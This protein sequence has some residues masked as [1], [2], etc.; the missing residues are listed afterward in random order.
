[1]AEVIRLTDS[2]DEPSERTP[3]GW[4]Q[5]WSKEKTAADKRLRTFTNQGN[6]VV[7]RFLDDRGSAT[8]LRGQGSIPCR[9]NL[10]WRNVSTLQAMLYGN[11]PKID[12]SREHH[13]PDDDIARVAATLYERMLQTDI[14]ASGEDLPT[15]LKCALQDRLI[16]GLGVC[17]VRYTYTS[18]EITTLD[19][20]TLQPVTQ[21]QVENESAPVDYVHWQDFLWGWGRT[22]SEI[23]WLGFRSWLTKEEAAKR[24]NEKIAQNLQYK[25]QLPQGDDD[26]DSTGSYSD[27]E[28]KN[29]IQ[30]AEVWEFWCKKDRKVYWFSP[31][32]D[33]I[34][35]IKDDP[36]ELDGFWPTVRPMM[37][38]L[39]TTLFCPVADYI[40]A[41]DLYAEI[42]ILQSRIASITRAIKVVG[43]YDKGAG[44]SVGRMLKEGS[45][46]QLIP[47][48]NWAMFSEKGGLQGTIQWFPVQ[49]VVGTLK[50][51][52][53]IQQR[54]IQQLYEITGMSDLLRGGNTDQY[55]SD[56]TNQLKAKFG[57][58]NVQALQDEFARFASDLEGL[59]A[60]VISKHFT[61]QSISKQS[62]AMYMPQADRDKIGPA[63]ELM[64]SPDIKWRVDIR[65]E[66]IAM[67]D[68][69]QLKQERTEYLTAIAT[70]LQSAT[71]M[72]K[73]VPESLPLL[74][75]FMK[76]G[77]VGFK[78][79]NYMEGILDQAIDMAKKA[80][81]KQDQKGQ[82]QQQMLQMQMQGE[83]QKI[84]AKSQ[85]DLQSIN[86][87]S[88]AE[89]AKIQMDMQ[90][91]L[92]SLQAKSQG[93]MQ[94]IVA[95]LRA[96]MQII[97]A[98][99]DA[100][101]QREAAQSEYAVAEETVG[102]RNRMREI[103]EQGDIAEDAAEMETE[104]ENEPED[105]MED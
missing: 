70:Y 7:A 56:G 23:P 66:S 47:V 62:N 85:A 91:D 16:P 98:K 32:A 46:N 79:S 87:K 31:G 83:L 27:S 94:K 1:M 73:E 14:E 58:I 95:D 29:N 76:F 72:A 42:D 80:P 44:D 50:V 13:D 2:D 89:L 37:A 63:I 28:Q 65:P 103:E 48:D 78:G 17:R 74:L 96:D 49:E 19:P 97:A 75:E 4:H 26:R 52:Q 38:N 21:E 77:M 84:Q 67:I 69:A 8:A 24:F 22:W 25:N 86:A 6:A 101:L 100:D 34:L 93:D 41:Q 104:N 88:Q 12:V 81:P 39:T 57:S 10:Y 3:T 92:A 33:M 18:T 43:V 60:E 59:K 51:L 90:S 5:Y 55:T 35:D 54:T 61:P 99:L 105:D 68:Y 64:K 11:T 45:E 82:E 30:K 40:F 36:L 20:Q 102:H 53:E 71:S 9:L 15:A